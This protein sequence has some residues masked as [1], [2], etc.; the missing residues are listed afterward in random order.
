MDAL[1]TLSNAILRVLER[2]A[3]AAG[4]LLIVLMTVTCVDVVCR[5]LSI[6]IPYTK[7]QE[8]EWHLHA[9]IFSLWM[10]YCYCIN[11]HPR[12]DSYTE[13]LPFR[14]RAWIELAGCLLFALPYMIVVGYFA[15]DF[16]KISYLQGEG[17]ENLAGLHHRWVIK[18][19]FV[20]GLILV[21]LA[22]V[23]VILRLIAYLF[24]RRPQE[25][26]QLRIGHAVSDV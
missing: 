5:K 12:V 11:A 2:V 18:G 14:V 17:S 21:L 25:Q 13:T 15:L 9:A 20:A 4:W 8:M 26:V 6:P 19:V 7:F 24:G 22:V 23:S 10:G 1:L 3:Y 16:L